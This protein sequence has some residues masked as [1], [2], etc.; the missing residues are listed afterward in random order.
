MRLKIRSEFTYNINFI[1]AYFNKYFRNAFFVQM[2]SICYA[3]FYLSFSTP[4]LPGHFLEMH[5]DPY[6]LELRNFQITKYVV[7]SALG[8][9]S[10]NPAD[11]V[12]GTV[13][14]IRGGMMRVLIGEP[15]LAPF[16]FYTFTVSM[17]APFQMGETW[18]FITR[19][20]GALPTN[21]NDAAQGELRPGIVAPFG[22]AVTA[23]RRSPVAMI[24]VVLAIDP[25]NT[26]PIE[27]KVISPPNLNFT[28]GSCL[29]EMNMATNIISCQP[30]QPINGHAQARL[31]TTQGG[32][33][34]PVAV[35]LKMITPSSTPAKLQ[36]YVEAVSQ[37]QEV[38]GW[39]EDTRGFTIRQMEA[40]ILYTGVPN[41]VSELTVRFNTPETLDNGGTIVV[42]HPSGFEIQ[43]DGVNLRQIS[44]PGLSIPCTLPTAPQAVPQFNLTLTE[45]LV[46]GEYSFSVK[47][48]IPAETPTNNVFSI[49]LFG[50]DDSHYARDAAINVMGL[51]IQPGLD[52][53]GEPIEWTRSQPGKLSGVTL[54]FQ[55]HESPKSDGNVLKQRIGEILINFPTGF[56][57]QVDALSHVEVSRE[58]LDTN[59]PTIPG[60]FLLSPNWLDYTEKDRLRISLM[61]PP[62]VMENGIYKFTFLVQIPVQMPRDNVW[63]VSLCE[64]NGGCISASDRTVLVV[65][66]IPGFAAG[67]SSGGEI[68]QSSNATRT[69]GGLTMTSSIAMTAI[70]G[71]AMA[72]MAR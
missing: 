32:L 18:T 33:N 6:Q 65:F 41:V 40:S 23:V 7:S 27:I 11:V 57:H 42:L 67:E 70:G 12:T 15:G 34:G 38:I 51:A 26:H 56:K 20:G 46:F 50:K 9:K 1:S 2:G 72:G 36:W 49:Q 66:P 24:D 69:V 3:D 16:T 58:E 59:T 19:D 13:V 43:C 30:Q 8:F 39:G 60:M 5:G 63:T 4:V 48:R 61:S 17:I 45:T 64:A 37:T 47:A 35:T 25:L 62:G 53:R 14:E 31:L 28:T 54:G 21:T 10:D 71:A 44:L 29:S 52:L 55:V 68:I 22:L